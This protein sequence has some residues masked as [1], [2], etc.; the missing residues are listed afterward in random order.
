[1]VNLPLGTPTWLQIPMGRFSVN[2]KKTRNEL[3]VADNNTIV[4]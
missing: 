3:G 4:S 1:M 2:K